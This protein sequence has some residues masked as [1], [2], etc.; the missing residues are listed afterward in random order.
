MQNRI[1]NSELKTEHVTG[2]LHGPRLTKIIPLLDAE[3]LR[4][5]VGRALGD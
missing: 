1:Q 5:R 3:T 2:N 4:R